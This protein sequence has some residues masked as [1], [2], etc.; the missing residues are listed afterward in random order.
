MQKLSVPLTNNATKHTSFLLHA[1]QACTYCQH[2]HVLSK[3]EN[4]KLSDETDDAYTD[5]ACK[6]F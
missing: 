3:P 1:L 2:L 5:D 6:N 4:W